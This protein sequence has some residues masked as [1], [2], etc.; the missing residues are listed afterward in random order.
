LRFQNKSG[1]SAQVQYQELYNIFPGKDATINSRDLSLSLKKD[2]RWVDLIGKIT[3]DSNP[4]TTKKDRIK[5]SGYGAKIKLMGDCLHITLVQYKDTNG[6][7]NEYLTFDF[8]WAG[9]KIPRVDDSIIS[10]F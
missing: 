5:A 1:D 6:N 9:N 8:S 4:D 3:Y 7:L 2:L 10:Q